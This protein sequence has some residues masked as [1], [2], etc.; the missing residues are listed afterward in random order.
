MHHTMHILDALPMFVVTFKVVF[1]LCQAQCS[2]AFYAAYARLRD[3][4]QI[5]STLYSCMFRPMSSKCILSTGFTKCVLF[6]G[7]DSSNSGVLFIE[8]RPHFLVVFIPA[9]INARATYE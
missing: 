5:A 2:I 3:F 7:L 8:G 9:V 6:A 4:T 1:V